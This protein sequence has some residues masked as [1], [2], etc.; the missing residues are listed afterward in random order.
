MLYPDN[1]KKRQDCLEGALSYIGGNRL[2]CGSKCGKQELADM[3][4]YTDG[5]IMLNNGTLVD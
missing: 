4:K 3:I 2:Q 5:T 1:H